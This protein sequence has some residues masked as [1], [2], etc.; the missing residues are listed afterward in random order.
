[1]ERGWRALEYSNCP[2]ATL[3]TILLIFVFKT[4]IDKSHLSFGPAVQRVHIENQGS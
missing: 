4:S 3:V 1:M 2:V